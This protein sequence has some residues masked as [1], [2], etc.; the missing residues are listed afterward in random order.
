MR[1]VTIVT[2][3]LSLISVSSVFI[4]FVNLLLMLIKRTCNCDLFLS[5]CIF[6][7]GACRQQIY[8]Q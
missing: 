1:Y 5:F 2:Y 6:I 4:N 8:A 7:F 3:S